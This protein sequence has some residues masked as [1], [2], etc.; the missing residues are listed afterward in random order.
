[1]LTGWALGD[2]RDPIN[3][4]VAAPDAGAGSATV[5]SPMLIVGSGSSSLIVPTP[6][7]FA[8][9]A[10]T[11]TLR[12]TR[13]VSLTSEIVSPLTVTLTFCDWMPAGNVSVLRL[14]AV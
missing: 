1:M 8:N 7:L 9:V 5:I 11:G 10:L 3:V 13:N 2:E 12:L 4:A 14:T 6:W